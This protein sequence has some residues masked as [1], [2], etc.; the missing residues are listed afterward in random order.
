MSNEEPARDFR[1]DY[2]LEDL[3]ELD[4]EMLTQNAERKLKRYNFR[5]LNN[6][7]VFGHAVKCFFEAVATGLDNL[8]VKLPPLV[9]QSIM[10]SPQS[11]VKD[12][13]VE[14]RTKYRGEE[15]WQNG[16][17]IFKGGELAY[18]IG[19]PTLQKTSPLL[20]QQD[21]HWVVLTNVRM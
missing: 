6:P 15:E 1:D 16:T 12:V 5:G 3:A 18:F 17:Y 4:R 9:F 21:P 8:G 13:Q 2:Y 19:C 11:Q 20:I 7:V 10:Q 14:N